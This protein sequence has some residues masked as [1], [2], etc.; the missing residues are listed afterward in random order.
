TGGTA[1]QSLRSDAALTSKVRLI[2]HTDHGALIGLTSLGM[3]PAPKEVMDRLASGET[4][5][6]SEYYMRVTPYFET[7]S[8]K[9][10]WL[11]PIVSVGYGHRMS[12]GA[13][14]QV[15]EIL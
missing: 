11:N 14:Y 5:S 12:G 9:Y 7:A 15:F 4:L 13:I 2:M 3:R 10:G 1:R 8:E 6:P